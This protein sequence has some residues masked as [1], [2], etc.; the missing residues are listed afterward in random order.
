MSHASNESPTDSGKEIKPAAGG[1]RKH[2]ILLA[3]G[4]AATVLWLGFLAYLA[5]SE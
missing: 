2:P 3:I 4:A 1:A 5:F